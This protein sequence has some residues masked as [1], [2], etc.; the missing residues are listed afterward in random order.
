MSI[1]NFYNDQISYLEKK[2]E[3]KNYIILKFPVHRMDYQLVYILVV[4]WFFH[5]SY[6][7]C[8]VKFLVSS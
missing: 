3:K 7:G 2:K 1:D 8:Y 5:I 4:S 6:E